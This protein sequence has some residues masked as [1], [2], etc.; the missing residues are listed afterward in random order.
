MARHERFTVDAGPEP[1]TVACY[2]RVAGDQCAFI[3]ASTAPA[4]PRLMAALSAQG[5]APGDVRWVV[6]THAHLDHAA[7]SAALLAACPNATLLAHPRAARNLVDPSR[8]VE[9]ATL[10]YGQERFLELFG[11]VEPVPAAR[12]RALADGEAFD[13]G[14]A[15]LTAWHTAGH[16]YH[17]FVVDDPATESVYTGDAFGLVY[18]AVQTHGR[19]AMASTSPTG[20]D[21]VEARRSLARVVALGERF[22]CLTHF[23]AYDDVEA[24]AAQVGRFVDR[25]GAWVQEAA[26]GDEPVEAMATRLAAAWRRAIAEEAPGFGPEEARALALD[27]ELNAQ[28]LAHVAAALRSPRPP[29]R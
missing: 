20:F 8:L 26:R 15:R 11:Q 18:P 2:L 5:R 23:D 27:V 28:G 1:R 13:L 19:F 9:G 6:V 21:A 7:G 3:D 29:P 24:I 12:V 16:A 22:A 25:A 4:L 10:V 14:D 17:H